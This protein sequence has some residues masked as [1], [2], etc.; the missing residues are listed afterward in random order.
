MQASS[1]CD[2]WICGTNARIYGEDHDLTVAAKSRWWSW[3]CNI[4]GMRLKRIFGIAAAA[5]VVAGLL[6]LHPW[7]RGAKGATYSGTVETREIQVG[8]KLGGRVLAVGVEEGQR[9]KAG[10]MLVRFEANELTAERAQAD[11]QVG[12]AQADLERLESGYRPEEKEQTLAAAAQQRAALDEAKNGPRPQELAQAQAD[13]DAAK[14]NAADAAATFERMAT[15][16]RGDTISRMQ[17]DDAKAKRDST[18][19]Q[20]ESLRQRL[21][22]LQAGTRSEDLRAA[23]ARYKQAQAAADLMQRGNRREDIDAARGV[24]AAAIAHRKALDAQLTE[25]ELDAPADGAIEVVSV[26]PGDLVPPGKIV[27]DMLEA[28]Q[29][30][31]KIYVPETELG[32]VKIGQAAAISVDTF[33]GREFVGHVQ[34]IA[35]EAEFLPRNVQTRDDREHEVFGVK[36]QLDAAD[37]VLK[38]GMSATVRVR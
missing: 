6:L 21:A 25:A 5:I 9:V 33:P 13:Y 15:L 30:W 17:F 14:A 4:S 1:G 35:S 3:A 36:V 32:G 18:A 19:Q 20:A 27:I 11:A 8:S 28:S 10:A 16:V 2:H 22:L 38:S 23:E 26:R 12:Q 24:L 34:E 29:L 31:V 7:N 37:G